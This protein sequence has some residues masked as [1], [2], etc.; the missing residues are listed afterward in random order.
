[1]VAKQRGEELPRPELAAAIAVQGNPLNTDAGWIALTN[2]LLDVGVD[3]SGGSVG[4]AYGN[5]LAE[6]PI[7]SFKTEQINRH[8]LWPDVNDVEVVTFEGSAS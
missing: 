8:G 4:D 3:A 2:R 5:V 7:R 6:S 1:M